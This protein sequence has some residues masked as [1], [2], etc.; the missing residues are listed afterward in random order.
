MFPLTLMLHP[1]RFFNQV[2][3]GGY[4]RRGL[5]VFTATA[6]T[7]VLA[8]IV[9][10]SKVVYEVALGPYSLARIDLFRPDY[11]VMSSLTTVFVALVVLVGV[12]RILGRFLGGT[13]VPMRV[14]ITA[15]MYLF[16]IM[17]LVN[18]VYMGLAYTSPSETYYVMGAEF[19]DV[20]FHDARLRWSNESVVNE[21]EAGVLYAREASVERVYFNGSSVK[22]GG[23]TARELDNILKSTSLRAVLKQPQAPP[24]ELPPTIVVEDFVSSGV[25]AK[26]IILTSVVAVS[27]EPGIF[28][29][30]L[31]FVRSFLW[32]ALMSVYL[33]VMVQTL[34]KTKTKTTILVIVLAFLAVTYLV[35]TLF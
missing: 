31:G 30:Q 13:T 22:S 9:Y 34:H 25:E 35:P 18:I 11:L 17:A 14:F 3:L 10:S 2:G 7:Q 32:R 27:N 28:L 5:A 12:G 33:G 20:V 29:V 4:T 19:R 26:N 24:H 16:T 21:V 6:L 8:S 15:T 1:A 23:Y